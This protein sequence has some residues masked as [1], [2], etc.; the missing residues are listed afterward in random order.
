MPFFRKPGL[1]LGVQLTVSPAMNNLTTKAPPLTSCCDQSWEAVTACFHLCNV[2]PDDLWWYSLLPELT[3]FPASLFRRTRWGLCSKWWRRIIARWRAFLQ[4]VWRSW[5]GA[6]TGRRRRLR[7]PRN[8]LGGIRGG[9]MEN[10][11]RDH[12]VEQ[13]AAYTVHARVAPVRCWC[14]Y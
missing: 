10:G 4:I 3:C 9:R 8:K 6:L 11:R 14:S 1:L 13:A 7:P 2:M 12:R 5:Y